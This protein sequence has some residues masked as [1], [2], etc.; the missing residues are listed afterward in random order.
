MAASLSAL[1]LGAGLLW[2]QRWELWGASGTDAALWGLTA[3][4]LLASAPPLVPPGYPA[5]VAALHASGVALVPAAVAVSLISAALVPGAVLLAARAAGA[6]RGAGVLAALFAGLCAD[7]MGFAQQVQPD[8]LIALLSVALAGLLA[9]ATRGSRG[10]ALAAAALAGVLPLVREHG[11]VLALVAGVV[12]A[13]TPA[14]RRSA[15]ALLAV[16]WLSP[17]LV[18]VL[19]GLHPL[20]TP[21]GARPGG[22]LMVL[23]TPSLEDVPYARTL[24]PGPRATYLGLVTEAD[25]LGLVR[26]HAARALH[27]AWDGWL[28]IAAALALAVASR[29]R[30]LIAL[31]LPLLA[32]APAL[33]IWAQRR[34]VL[35][36]VPLAMAALAAALAPLPS[37]LSPARPRWPRIL[38]VL[39][40]AGALAT[41]WSRAWR[42]LGPAQ[43]SEVMRAR[44]YADVAGWLEEHAPE[45]SLLGGVFQDVGLYV[46][47]PRHDPDGTR[48]DWRTYWVSD[49]APEERA[50]ERVYSGAGGL[51]VYQRSP[52]LEPRPCA[53]ARPAPGSPHLA[54]AAAHAEL[55]AV[56]AGCLPP[57]GAR[58]AGAR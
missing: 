27:L 7:G 12:L 10:A 25:R 28:L 16:L 56:D 36:M 2:R 55:I 49:R 37:P 40:L 20:A 35:V 29:R 18:G 11:L 39:L 33:L 30:H 26:F 53:D 32:A 21:W 14:T 1:Q 22:A 58:G 51:G 50:W 41:P 47:M 46:S 23:G 8:S 3:R 4:D 45:G 52:G 15:L 31:A 38:G 57:E 44:S 48:A 19:P 5:L 43:Q 54:V 34:H 17:L 13:W 42:A 9:L 24:P 6:S